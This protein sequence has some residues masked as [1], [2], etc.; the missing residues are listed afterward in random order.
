M[1]IGLID[2]DGHN[3][4]NL[5]L[6]KISAYHKA[7]GDTV[8]WFFPMSRYDRVYVAKVFDFTPD[9]ETIINAETVIYCG[10]GYDLYNKL[11][12]EIENTYPDY[13]LYGIKDTAYGYLTRGCPRECAFCIVS[14]KE[15]R[16]SHKVADLKQFWNGQRKIK[17]LD[18]NLLACKDRTEL[19]EQLIE[20]GAWIDFTQGL[21]IRFMDYY[22]AE[23]IKRMKVKMLHFAWDK[24]KD[25]EQII[26]NLKIFKAQT[27]ID[28]RKLKV[29]VL[30]NF[31]T[32]FEEDL[33]RIYTLKELGYDPYVMIYDK[34]NAPKRIRH[35]QRW[36]N[37][38]IVFRTCEKF[39][40]YKSKLA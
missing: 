18:P 23:Q 26:K 37:N 7:Q 15:G 33:Y 25:S 27:N 19:L 8:E 22:I 24:M 9:F 2:V 21:D 5:P 36:V 4:P 30:T 16:F 6:M 29:Y 17:L 34:K 31:D 10:T 40:D 35:L 12:V 3:F 14:K 39:E 28:Y 11:P 32:T 20:S 13:S 1:K 38:K